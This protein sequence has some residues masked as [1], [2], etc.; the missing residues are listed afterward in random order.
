[1]L[2]GLSSWRLHCIELHVLAFQQLIALVL[3]ICM[4]LHSLIHRTHRFDQTGYKE[5]LVLQVQMSQSIDSCL[6]G[7]YTAVGIANI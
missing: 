6:T 1:M 3:T 7:S 4:D 5:D 2:R